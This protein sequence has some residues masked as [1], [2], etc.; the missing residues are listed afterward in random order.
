MHFDN[1]LA[2]SF[3]KTHSFGNPFDVTKIDTTQKL[4]TE[5]KKEDYFIVHL[6]QG[7]H[8]FV[9]NI[10]N[11]YHNFEDIPTHAIQEWAYKRS[12]LNEYDTSESNIL[13]VGFNQRI[14][15]HFIYN[16]LSVNPKIY[17]SKKT[18]MSFDYFMGEQSIKTN[19][20]QIEIDM[21]IEHGKIVTL[22]EAKNG[23]S[24]DF[25]IYQIYLP[26]LYYHTLNAN[27][28]IGIKEINACY[29]LREQSNT[30]SSIRMYQYMFDDI[31]IINSIKLI[32]SA[33]YNLIFR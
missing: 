6:G 18:K 21:T 5:I 7:K 23:F 8:K 15:Y 10:S 9:K 28:K 13:S 3:C 17:N 29:L 14:I 16:D 30:G 32:K 25:S 26:C 2:K 22:F 31:N 11:G 27:N 12:L 1:E 24:K 19:N 20:L 33:Q 4:P